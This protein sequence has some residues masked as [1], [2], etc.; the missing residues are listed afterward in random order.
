MPLNQT[1]GMSYNIRLLQAHPSRIKCTYGR[2]RLRDDAVASAAIPAR[3][4]FTLGGT[5]R[6]AQADARGSGGARKR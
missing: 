2:L 1:R 6:R 4:R 3:K 5:R